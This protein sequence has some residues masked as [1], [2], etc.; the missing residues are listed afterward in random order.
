MLFQQVVELLQNARQQ[1]LRTVNSTMVCTYFEIG[2]IIVE[3]EQSGKDRAEYGKQILKGLSQQLTNEFGKG[4][5]VA[6][7]ENIR[8][9]YLAYSISETVSRILQ[10]QKSQS[11]TGVS[12]NQKTQSLTAELKIQGL[13]TLSSFFKLSWTHY[14]FLMRIDDEKE[15]RF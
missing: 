6:N 11:L 12:E 8:K 7:L 1:I 10:I 4:F 2:R 3:E 9:F 5:F 14:V 15:R 13:L